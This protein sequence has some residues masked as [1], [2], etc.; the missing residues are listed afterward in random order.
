M[1]AAQSANLIGALATLPAEAA[2]AG[3]YAERLGAADRAFGVGEP[4]PRLGGVTGQRLRSVR[5]AR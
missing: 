3:P 4:L 2:C 1:F 5:R